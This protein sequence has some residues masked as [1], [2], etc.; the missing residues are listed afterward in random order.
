[1][2]QQKFIKNNT[3]LMCYQKIHHMSGE[4]GFNTTIKYPEIVASFEY[5]GNYG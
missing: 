1:M 4:S 2:K 5:I 3:Y